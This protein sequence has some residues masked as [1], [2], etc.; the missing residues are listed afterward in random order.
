ME[1]SP[2]PHTHPLASCEYTENYLKPH[3]KLPA[4]RKHMNK[5]CVHCQLINE[6]PTAPWLERPAAGVSWVRILLE[7][8]KCNTR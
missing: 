6:A 3:P 7:C 8:S 1:F 4:S 2:P 5:S